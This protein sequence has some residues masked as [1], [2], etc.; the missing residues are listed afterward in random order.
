M[1]LNT[2]METY[3]WWGG[4]GVNMLFWKEKK[5]TIYSYLCLNIISCDNVSNSPQSRRN[6][7]IIIMPATIKR[8]D[9]LYPTVT[10]VIS[11]PYSQNPKDM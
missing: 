9:I 7:F 6:H 1:E 4:G 8:K 3:W 5:V 11:S 2:I 10:S